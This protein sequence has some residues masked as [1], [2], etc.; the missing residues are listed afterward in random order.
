MQ[1]LFGNLLLF[2]PSI[3]GIIYYLF[4]ACAIWYILIPSVS[5]SS[6]QESMLYH[7]AV[8]QCDENINCMNVGRLACYIYAKYVSLK[9][10][11]M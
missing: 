7:D 4:F 5:Y 3:L 11:L 10:I 1:F 9:E 2:Q 6:L 8:P